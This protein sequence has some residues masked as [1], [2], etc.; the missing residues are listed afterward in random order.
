MLMQ[1]RVHAAVR[2]QSDWSNRKYSLY[3]SSRM[4]TVPQYHIQQ[5]GWQGRARDTQIPR[6]PS[7]QG[8][9]HQATP[10][11][12]A[13]APAAQVPA[14]RV[15]TLGGTAA[16]AFCLSPPPLQ[17]LAPLPLPPFLGAPGLDPTTKERTRKGQS[18]M[19]IAPSRRP[20]TQTLL[21]CI[22]SH[23]TA[24]ATQHHTTT[25]HDISSS[26]QISPTR[27]RC[28][29]IRIH[30]PIHTHTHT[31]AYRTQ[32]CSLTHD[33]APYQSVPAP[34]FGQHRLGASP[35]RGSSCPAGGTIR[36]HTRTHARSDISHAQAATASVVCLSL[37]CSARCRS[38]RLALPCPSPSLPPDTRR[39]KHRGSGAPW[40]KVLEQNKWADNRDLT[41]TEMS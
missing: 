25:R 28:I 40:G 22:A 26:R 27:A 13:R 16:C 39:L 10:A 23:H 41:K 38:P 20:E 9:K 2:G 4:S 15:P 35:R 18:Q 33:H 14:R 37:R 32:I 3:P 34:P 12:V 31:Q 5:A 17:S 7:S 30:I 6:Y 29:H 21:P 24:H 8:P 11:L 19:R 36:T 1:K